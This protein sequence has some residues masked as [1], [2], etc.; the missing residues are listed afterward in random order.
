MY[1][2]HVGVPCVLRNYVA[3][4]EP[5]TN[6]TIAE[7][8]LATCASPPL[9]TSTSIE[10]DFATFEYTGGDLGLS[11]PTGEIISEAH[12]AF[13][14]DATVA[15]LLSIG[16]GH[17]GV[18]PSPSDSSVATWID[19]LNRVTMDSEKTAREM[20]SRMKHLTLYH[21]LCVDYGLGA[22]QLNAWKDPV[23]ISTHT[24]TYLGD[25]E[26]AERVSHC[27]DTINHGDGFTTLEQL[28][29]C[30]LIIR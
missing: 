27:V 4:H 10:K 1:K 8:M 19:F 18:K 30:S 12:R 5:P 24:T 7:A 17:S 29:R 22:D 23:V 26:V 14:D 13:G 16:C 21:R 6:L 20:A 25:L 11:N 9:F 15:C 28:S 3:G 2:N